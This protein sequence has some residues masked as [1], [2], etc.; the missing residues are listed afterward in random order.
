MFTV[1]FRIQNYNLENTSHLETHSLGGSTADDCSSI[2][3]L[4]GFQVG[5]RLHVKLVSGSHNVSNDVRE[6]WA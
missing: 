6:T 5:F 3:D 2:S 4:F 1:E